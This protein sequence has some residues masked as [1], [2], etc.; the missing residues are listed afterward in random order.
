MPTAELTDLFI[1][2]VG[3]C[4]GEVSA[5][6]LLFAYGNIVVGTGTGYIDHYICIQ[7]LNTGVNV[8]D[9]VVYTLVLEAY[10]IEHTGRRFGH[11]W[12]WIAF[13]RIQS[14]AFYDKSSKAIE[15]DEVGEFF[16][17]TEGA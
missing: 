7:I 2:T 6:A 9:K 3:G 15:V 16:S 5:V 14:G 11:A 10:G 1:G 12:I 13:T 4:I 17:I 8:F